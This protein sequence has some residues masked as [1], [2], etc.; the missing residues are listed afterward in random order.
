MV[1][2]DS[3]LRVKLKISLESSGN[4]IKDRKR[5]IDILVLGM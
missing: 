4:Q 2:V 3:K 1:I 5:K